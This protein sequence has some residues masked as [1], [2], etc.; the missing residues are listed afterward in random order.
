MRAGPQSCVRAA[1]VGTAAHCIMKLFEAVLRADPP[2]PVAVTVV[3]NSCPLGSVPKKRLLIDGHRG[4]RRGRLAKADVL[5][6]V[7]VDV[8]DPGS[9]TSRCTTTDVPRF[10]QAA[11]SGDRRM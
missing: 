4:R 6:G 8:F 9:Q 10:R 5:Y 11:S 2:G 7:P 3:K 1:A